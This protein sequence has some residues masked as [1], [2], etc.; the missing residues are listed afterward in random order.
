MKCPAGNSHLGLPAGRCGPGRR[1][2][3]LPPP[4][5]P[6][7]RSNC[8]AAGGWRQGS[9]R[10]RR[11]PPAWA[12]WAWPAC[13]S[14]STCGSRQRHRRGWVRYRWGPTGASAPA[15]SRCFGAAAPRAPGPG[16]S[17]S[18]P[19]WRCQ[20]RRWCRQ[21]RRRLGA[22]RRA[23]PR[24]AHGTARRCRPP[25]AGAPAA[26]GLRGSPPRP[27][28]PALPA[29]RPPQWR[30]ALRQCSRLAVVPLP[31]RPPP[32][33]AAQALA[34]VQRVVRSGPPAPPLRT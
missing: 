24:G 12:R 20:T 27:A 22:V 7:S 18:C 3:L 17:R 11:R 25:A 21:S 14:P 28:P 30:A 26:D 4:A 33:P 15:W 10:S 1:G 29:G 34:R 23:P 9:R 8:W 6:A 31:V 5:S 19:P 2:L 16:P 32:A 13:S